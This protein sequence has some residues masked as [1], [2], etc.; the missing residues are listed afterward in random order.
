MVDSDV[1]PSVTLHPLLP[2]DL[3]TIATFYVASVRDDELFAYLWPSLDSCLERFRTY[4]L[5][6]FKQQYH[7]S[8]TC[9]F[10]AR[11]D[12]GAVGFSAWKRIGARDGTAWAAQRET[13]F[14]LCKV[15]PGQANGVQVYRVADVHPLT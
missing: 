7:S 13:S 11:I 3:P 8:D 5:T 6:R 15:S 1:N 12:G 10:V 14:S 9:M 2:T 4:C